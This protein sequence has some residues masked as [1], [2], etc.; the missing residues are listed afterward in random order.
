MTKYT[1]LFFALVLSTGCATVK[2]SA[3]LGGAIGAAGG[4]TSGGLVHADGGGDR[5]KNM[6]IGTAVGSLL[7]AGIGYLL[8][9]DDRTGG[10]SK[11]ISNYSGLEGEPKLLPAQVD[12]LFVDD[13]V[14]GNTY[15]P[16]HFQYS[17][18]KPASW[19]K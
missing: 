17:I 14:H 2:K 15:V 3:L 13:Q 4:A 16:G 12:T 5:A 10:S 1:W 8:H 11:T 19:K 6:L 7:G 18:K 9:D